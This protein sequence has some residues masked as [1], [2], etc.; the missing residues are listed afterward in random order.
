MQPDVVRQVRRAE[1]VLPLPSAPWQAVQSSSNCVRLGSIARLRRRGPTAT[2]RRRRTSRH[3][4]GA[5]HGFQRRHRADAAFVDRG[6]RWSRVAAPEPVL[7][8][9]VGEA[10]APPP[11][12]PWQVEQLF[13]NRLRPTRQCRRI[14]ASSSIGLPA[15]C[16]SITCAFFSC[17]ACIGGPLLLLGPAQRPLVVAHSRVE[18]DIADR[19][20]HAEDEQPQPPARQGIVVLRRSPSQTCPV[21]SSW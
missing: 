18:H 19:E 20:D 4:P 9:E 2:A 1:R 8:G 21:V 11:S 12:E 5:E 6:T 3:P 13:A 10:G 16:A 14:R 17:S 7:V 15:N